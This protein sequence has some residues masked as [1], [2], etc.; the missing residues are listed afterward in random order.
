MSYS[1]GITTEGFAQAN[2]SNDN[3]IPDSKVMQD[4][5]RRLCALPRMQAATR[6]HAR[7][8]HMVGPPFQWN[9]GDTDTPALCSEQKDVQR[10]LS[11][12]IS[13]NN[14]EQQ[15]SVVGRK[16]CVSPPT[17]IHPI[18]S[19]CRSPKCS[20]NNLK[21]QTGL[22]VPGTGRTNFRHTNQLK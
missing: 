10:R 4:A 21:T 15:R 11:L 6:S 1:T 9:Y 14:D 20:P 18:H 8:D 22:M 3:D 12:H 2:V 13:L 5:A 16:V 19:Y 17:S 7:Q